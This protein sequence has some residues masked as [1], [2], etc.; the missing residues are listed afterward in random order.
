MVLNGQKIRQK[1]EA[2]DLTRIEL[3]R[4]LKLDEKTIYNV[5]MNPNHKPNTDTV[6]RI[7]TR[8]GLTIADIYDQEPVKTPA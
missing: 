4:E 1:R 3:G 6:V 7:A 5:E 2:L 8:L